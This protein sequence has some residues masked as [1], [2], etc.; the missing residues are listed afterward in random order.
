MDRDEVRTQFDIVKKVYDVK[1]APPI[2]L[3]SVSG[4]LKTVSRSSKMKVILY[5]FG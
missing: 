2:V 1:N 5:G 4:V 3:L